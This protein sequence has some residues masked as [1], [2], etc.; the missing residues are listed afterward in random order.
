[1]TEHER[2]KSG[3]FIPEY[4][5]AYSDVEIRAVVYQLENGSPE[6]LDIEALS[7]TI[8]TKAE[9]YGLP[10]DEMNEVLTAL[11]KATPTQ[12]PGA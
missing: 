6:T 12:I 5:P 2:R 8:A 3:E 11:R 1:M 9:E 7:A 4:S 10:I